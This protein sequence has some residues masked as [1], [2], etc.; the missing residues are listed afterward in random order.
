M[1][2]E[3]NA[4]AAG[5]LA[6]KL[7]EVFVEALDLDGGVDVENLKYRDIEAWDS[8]GHMALVAAIED[9]FDVEFD[10]DQVIDM[11]SFKVAVDMV[12]EL[13]SKND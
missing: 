1:S 8:V 4:Q 6:P 2:A 11:S 9:E 13:Q 5:P 12:T 7:R 10:T 3:L